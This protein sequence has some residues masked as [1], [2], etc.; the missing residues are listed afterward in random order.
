M[1]LNFL[2]LYL[3]TFTTNVQQP[4][5]GILNQKAPSWEIS[6]WYQLPAGKK[7]LD[8]TD[9]EGKVVYL[10]CFQSWCPGCHKYGF[11]TLQYVMRQFQDNEDVAFV[12]VQTTFEGYGFNS[13]KKAKEVAKKYRLKIPIGQD[14]KKGQFPKLMTHYR[15]GGTPWIIIIDKQGVVRFNYFYE[16][17]EKLVQLISSLKTKS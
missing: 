9:F 15:T 7:S 14:G 2:L 11:P 13:L 12:A 4:V 10:Y 6:D 1:L 5:A 17:P 3:F 16:Q 8:V